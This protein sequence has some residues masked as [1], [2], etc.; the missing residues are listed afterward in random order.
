MSNVK[1]HA[2]ALAAL[3]APLAFAA[4]AAAQAEDNEFDKSTDDVLSADEQTK[5][6]SKQGDKMP[7]EKDKAPEPEAPSDM[8][9]TFEKDGQRY[10][11]VGLRFRNLIVPQF[12]INLFADGGATVNVFTIGPELST[13]KDGL[14][15]DLALSYSDYSMDE[16]L[17]KGKADG[18]D[19]YEIVSSDMKIL[20]FTADLLYEIPLDK[21]KGRFSVLIGGGVGLGVVFG[22]LKRNQA[23]PRDNTDIDGEDVTKWEKCP[24]VG[25]G[26]VDPGTGNTF[27]DGSND[28]YGG[29]DEPSWANGG[30]KPSVF[31]WISIPQ[32]SFRYKPMK[33]LQARLDTGFSISGFFIGAS[34]G[35]GL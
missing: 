2:L 1:A 22:D 4:P 18:D 19:A 31:P 9:D 29:Y 30:S 3:L 25:S 35:Y 17:F 34:A 10:N 21:E 5:D 15:I 33:H 27:C 12:M 14:E 13:R 32:I 7:G 28:H 26:N 11:F 16:F 8:F 24:G 20:Y 6:E 23:Y